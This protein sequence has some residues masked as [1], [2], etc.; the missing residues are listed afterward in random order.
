MRKKPRVLLLGDSIRG[1]YQPMVSE[2]LSGEADVVAPAENGQFA[3][4]TLAC[5]KR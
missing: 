5:L 1:S 3:L 2:M 4:Y